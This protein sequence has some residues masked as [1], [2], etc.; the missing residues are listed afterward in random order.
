MQIPLELK[1]LFLVNFTPLL[2][3][4][5]SILSNWFNKFLNWMERI[6]LLKSIILPQFLFLFR[7]LPIHVPMPKLNK[8]QRMLTVFVWA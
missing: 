8:W 4:I 5:Q 3:R 6:V 7:T 1:A 2:Q